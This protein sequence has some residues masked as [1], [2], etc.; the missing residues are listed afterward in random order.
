MTLQMR[1]QENQEIGKEIG[2]ELGK[3]LGKEL[4]RKIGIG[5]GEK[6]RAVK[7]AETM[8]A[9]KEPIEKIVLYT[10]LSRE[11]IK[12]LLKE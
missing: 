7:T 5:L 11:E 8:L 4:G 12:G 6:S 3:E 9:Q 1:D 2:I 10:G